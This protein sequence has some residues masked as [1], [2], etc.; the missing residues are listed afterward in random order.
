VREILRAV[1]VVLAATSLAAAGDAPGG[2][3]E[4]LERVPDAGTVGRGTTIASSGIRSP[5][6]SGAIQA[7]A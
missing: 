3:L 1:L 4:V 7:P 5:A 6:K 2:R